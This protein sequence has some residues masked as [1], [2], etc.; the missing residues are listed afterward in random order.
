MKKLLTFALCSLIALLGLFLRTDTLANAVA[1]EDN[2][3]NQYVTSPKVQLSGDMMKKTE[4][5]YY[6]FIRDLENFPINFVYRD[7]YYSG[8]SSKF[9]NLFG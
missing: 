4:Q 6:N 1:N 5:E 2:G 8:F 3:D 9:F 7:N